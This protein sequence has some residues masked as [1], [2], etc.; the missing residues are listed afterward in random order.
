[1]CL[2]RLPHSAA[3]A[4]QATRTTMRCWGLPEDSTADAEL[5]ACELV[6]NAVLHSGRLDTQEPGHCR[7]TLARPAPDTVRIE[8]FDGSM[9]RPAKREP[10]EDE[11]GGRG[12]IL[13]AAVAADWGVIRHRDGKTVWALLKV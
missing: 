13:V 4:R 1:M 10:R 3:V 8:V 5:V 11:T 9:A 7:L 6:T 2:V 12:L